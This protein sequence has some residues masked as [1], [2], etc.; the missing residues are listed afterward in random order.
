MSAIGGIVDLRGGL[1]VRVLPAIAAAAPSFSGVNSTSWNDDYAG[2]VHVML[3]TTP[4]AL[5][6]TQPWRDRSGTVITF[7]GRVDNR[8]ELRAM[9]GND[10]PP[11]DAPDCVIVLAAWRRLGADLL[12]RLVGDY[13]FAIWDPAVRRLTVVR[14]PV[15]WCPLLWTERPGGIAFATEPAMLV[16]GLALSPG[17]DEATVGEMLSLRFVSET[18]SFWNGIQRLPAG[19]LLEADAHGIRTR[20]WLEGPFADSS[21]LSDRDHIDRFTELFDQ[22]IVATTRSAGPVAAFLSG[23]LDSSS[24]VCRSRQLVEAGKLAAMPRTLSGR[25]PGDACDEGEWIAAVEERCGIRTHDIVA[26][27]YDWAAATAWTAQSLHLPLRPT[28]AS[29]YTGSCD[30]LQANDTRVLL[31]GEGGDEW[32]TGGRS[33]FPDLLRAGR[34]RTLLQEGLSTASNATVAQ[35]LR[36]TASSAIGPIVSARQRAS[37]LFPHLD[38]IIHPP[39]WIRP[40]WAR[41]IGLA[42][43]WRH[44]PQPPALSG[45]APQQR[46]GR[47]SMARR[48]IN[49]DNIISW[50]SSRQIEMRH[51][52]HDFRL[53]RFLLG[54]AG[55]MLQRN[56]LR[57][58]LLR[59]AMRGTLP[60]ALIGRRD[61][62]NMSTPIVHAVTERLRE[63]PIHQL[64]CVRLGWIDPEPLAAIEREHAAWRAG[65]MIGKM[66][67]GSYGAVWNAVAADLWLEHAVGMG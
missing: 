35:R 51:P 33:H 30:W 62:A 9:I 40:D 28:A 60:D 64:S 23:G 45:L 57:K 56:G 31:T 46:Y 6:E 54:A 61:K 16:R 53:T 7:D 1:D 65:G 4:E 50:V 48:H 41:R 26:A 15:G 21:R 25:F 66:P 12:D 44:A 34:L 58:H 22:A 59:E 55:G 42:D 14:S 3:A 27:P 13:A 17:V 29:I 49:L 43:R 63:R 47:Y 5:T 2:L 10:A 11:R 20:R 52:L 8:D 18:A 19:H 32:L 38:F 67:H 39:A 37:L 36:L 24:V